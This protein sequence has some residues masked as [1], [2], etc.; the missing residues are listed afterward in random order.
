MAKYDLTDCSIVI[1]VQI[2]SS[3]RLEHLHFL[4]SFFD[5]H[6]VNH[7]LIVVEH[8]IESKVQPPKNAVFQFVR[9]DEEFST[10]LIS[11]VGASLVT[12]PFFCKYDVDAVVEPKAIFDAFVLLK[13]KP[14]VSL[15]MP[16][17]GV[18][19]NIKNPLRQAILRSVHLE[20]LPVIS[21]GEAHLLSSEEISLKSRNS[22]GLIHHFRTSVFKAFGGYNEEFVGW[23]YED[24]E[25]L[26]RFAKL[27]IP[28]K[29]LKNYTA[30]HLDH[31]RAATTLR[32]QVQMTQNY[33][34]ALSIQEMSPQ[35][36]MQYIQ[37]WNRF[38]ASV[39]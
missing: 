15:V 29:R 10:A 38:S 36:I 14:K 20:K 21:R 2:D 33:Q 12:T 11:N 35:E 34:R 39:T 31:P 32:S 27:K 17:N 18:S 24:N 13:N 16:Y 7:Q 19:F 28:V 23:G 22:K 37:T 1:P 30:F 9:S 26:A 4:F 5:A 25:I 3:H 8:G 6:F